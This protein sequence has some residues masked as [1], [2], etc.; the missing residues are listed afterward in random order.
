MF[1]LVEHPGR[2]QRAASACTSFMSMTPSPFRSRASNAPVAFVFKAAKRMLTSSASIF[3]SAFRSP[4]SE[5]GTVTVA[6]TIWPPFETVIVVVPG[7]TPVTK[8]VE[9]TVATA[10]FPEENAV[11]LDC[12]RLTDDPSESVPWTVRLT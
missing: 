3:P 12:V 11:L 1:E 6:A 9:V 4:R 7:L 5:F 2:V 8:P 10:M